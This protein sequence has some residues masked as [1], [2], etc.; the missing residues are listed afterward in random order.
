MLTSSIHMKVHSGVIRSEQRY[1]KNVICLAVMSTLLMS[2]LPAVGQ[3]PITLIDDRDA[4]LISFNLQDVLGNTCQIRRRRTPRLPSQQRVPNPALRNPP[5]RPP[6]QPAPISPQEQQFLDSLSADERQLYTVI[7]RAKKVLRQQVGADTLAVM[8]GMTPKGTVQTPQ[9]LDREFQTILRES[10]ASSRSEPSAKDGNPSIAAKSGNRLINRLLNRR[11]NETHEQW[12]AR[13]DPL[14]FATPGTE[15]EAWR[16][17]LSSVDKQAYD[18]LARAQRQ[19]QSEE[20]GEALKDKIRRDLSC[21]WVPAPSGDVFDK[22]Q[23]CD[24]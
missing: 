17:T 23:V 8:M 10:R 24:E 13:I 11:N 3:S 14:V 2:A 15:Y 19:R 5:S 20:V 12:H 22:I 21:R 18:R 9:D 4:S 7:Q 6:Q 1:G 16:S